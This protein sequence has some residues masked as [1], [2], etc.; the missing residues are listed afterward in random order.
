MAFSEVEK[1]LDTPV[2]RYS[3]GMY[4]RLAFAVAAFLEPETLII[5]EVLAVGD[6]GFQR[7]CLGK[8]SE[9]SRDGGR[10]VFFVSHNLGAISSLCK[11]ALYLKAGTPVLHGPVSE[12]V[13]RYFADSHSRAALWEART[14]SDHPLQVTSLQ[15]LSK[16]RDPGFEFEAAEGFTIELEYEVRRPV[17]NCIIELYIFGSDGTLLLNVADHDREPERFERRVP[18]KYRTAVAVPGDFLN[19]GSYFVHLNSGL[20][21]GASG[22]TFDWAETV[23]FEIVDHLQTSPRT[24][25]RGYVLPMLQWNTTPLNNSAHESSCEST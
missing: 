10:T 6:I 25:R 23:T 15:L 19:L 9:V 8:M 24:G 14:V 1:F 21:D 22:T 20:L 13:S 17:R 18:G 11:K 16:S 2:K 5:D 4:V 3:S 7:K 12:V